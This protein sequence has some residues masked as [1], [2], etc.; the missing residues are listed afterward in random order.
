MLAP[1]QLPTVGTIS[2]LDMAE[3]ANGALSAIG[4]MLSGPVEPT[5]V[6][7]SAAGSAVTS[8]AGMWWHD[9]GHNVIYMRDQAD[10]T[11]IPFLYVD[12]AAKRSRATP[13]V[14]SFDVAAFGGLFDGVTDDTQAWLD[15]AA[16][17]QAAGGGVITGPLGRST[18]IGDRIAITA[19]NVSIDWVGTVLLSGSATFNAFD[20]AG[21]SVLSHPTL[22]ANAAAYAM[23]I[24][25]TALTTGVVAGGWLLMLKD[26][27][28]NGGAT[29]SYEF[30]TKIRSISGAG[31]YTLVLESPLPVAFATADS[32]LQLSALSFISKVGVSG[33]ITFD[34][35]SATG[36]TVH[37]VS[38]NSVTD[39]VFSGILGLNLTKGSTIFSQFGHGNL[40]KNLKSE[41]CGTMSM[42]DVYLLG[43]TASQWKNIQSLNAAGFGF[44]PQS[45]CYCTGNGVITERAVGRGQK[46]QANLFGR[47]SDL[48]SHGNQDNG[49]G[50]SVGSCYNVFSGVAAN[51]NLTLEGFWLSDQSNNNNRIYGLS[52]HGNGSRDVYI[53][54][55]DANNEFYGVDAGVVA[56]NAPSTLFHGLNGALISKGTT[57]PVP[58]FLGISG[59]SGGA[60][61]LPNTTAGIGADHWIGGTGAGPVF[62]NAPGASGNLN[63]YINNARKAIITSTAITSDVP[64][65]P[66]SDNATSLGFAANRWSAGFFGPTGIT[67]GTQTI[68]IN[69]APP[70]TGPWV[71]GSV[72][73]NSAP[74]VGQPKGWRCTVGGTPGTWVS[75]GNL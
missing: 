49:I 43:Q 14:E 27:P 59:A 54:A 22:A 9:T 28:N 18:V 57:S 25:V 34:G 40:Y 15:A 41:N 50:V 6:S 17:A 48:Q 75:M 66:T 12:E 24:S 45:C 39:S 61:K 55:T 51:S 38:A 68:D 70:S 65:A 26:A 8:R 16:E 20:F 46:Y 62:W 56:N 71:A 72:R 19:S 3:A 1:I 32:G 74:A 52:A 47:Y 58:D 60:L 7:L 37:G 42:S 30:I 69:T 36:T 63:F 21:A 33:R 44:Q 2:G 67:I 29:A 23:S 31:P 35:S 73:F 5:L 13:F 11:W 64:F 53:G 4:T 10:T